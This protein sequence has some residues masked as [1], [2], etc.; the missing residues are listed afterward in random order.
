MNKAD[1]WVVLRFDDG[2]TA[3]DDRIAVKG[4]YNS[5]YEADSAIPEAIEGSRYKV[6]RSRH[7]FEDGKP[8][9][10]KA[11]HLEKIQ[12]LALGSRDRWVGFMSSDAQ[13]LAIQ[14]LWR[15]LPTEKRK[16]LVPALALLT[17]V[18]VAKVIGAVAIDDLDAGAD[19]RLPNGQLVKV[20]HVLLDD[21]GRKSPYLQVKDDGELD[22]LALVLFDP[23]LRPRV[24]RLV[25]VEAVK[26]YGRPVS[27]DKVGLRVTQAL[28][29]FPGSREI[30]GGGL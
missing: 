2:T 3:L 27:G 9:L 18:A 4:V 16:S 29:E 19:L 26:L 25:P 1:A 24:A 11:D 15:E 13:L 14:Q 10:P 17:E 7:F 6:M 30:E 21:Q 5:K 8:Y 23:D 12:G 20:R 28:L 22:W